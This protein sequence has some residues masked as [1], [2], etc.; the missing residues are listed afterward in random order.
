MKVADNLIRILKTFIWMVGISVLLFILIVLIIQIPAVQNKIVQS[1]TSFISKKTHTKVEI[2][3]VRI[4]FP[5]SVVAEGLYLEDL[6][7]DT[8]LYAGKATINMTLWG[9]LKK[10]D[11]HQFLC[12]RKRDNQP[13]QHQNRSP[14]QL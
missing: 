7:Q 2:S 8:L 1:A 4:S 6:N 5:K 10:K 13:A 3:H 9:L 11:R 14:F 12:S